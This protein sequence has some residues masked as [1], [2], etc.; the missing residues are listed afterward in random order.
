MMPGN[1]RNTA[2]GAGCGLLA[3][4]RGRA[5]FLMLAGND[6]FVKA[7]RMLQR[8]V[9]NAVGRFPS[10]SDARDAVVEAAAPMMPMLVP[11]GTSDIDPHRDPKFA[12]I[13]NN[14]E[15]LARIKRITIAT[16]DDEPGRRLA[17]ELVRLLGRPRCSFVTWPDDCKD[18]NEV[19]VKQGAARLSE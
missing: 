3:R 16:D 9:E 10:P 17:A 6:N 8:F 19:L 15:R 13:A 14:W 5:Y 12:F 7:D 2:T 4:P 11:E 18:A 1:G